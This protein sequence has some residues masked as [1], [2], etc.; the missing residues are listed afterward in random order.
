MS[1]KDIAIH[2]SHMSQIKPDKIDTKYQA[3]S[4][5]SRQLTL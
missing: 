1:G 4:E 3:R 5:E 2:I